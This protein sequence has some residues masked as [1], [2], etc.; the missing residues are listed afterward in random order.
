MVENL[1]FEEGKENIENWKPFFLIFGKNAYSKEFPFKR[2]IGFY[3]RS[4]FCKDTRQIHNSE[5][6]VLACSYCSKK[7]Y[8]PKANN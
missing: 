8:K 6:A 4:W 3:N 1:K 7:Y 5:K 2:N